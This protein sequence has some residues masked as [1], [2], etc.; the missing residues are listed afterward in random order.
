MRLLCDPLLPFFV[1]ARTPLGDPSA[2][3]WGRTLGE[4]FLF[5][6]INKKM[7]RYE[8]D[9][10]RIVTI[11]AALLLPMMLRAY[12]FSATVASGQT[13]YFNVVA[14]GVQVVYPGTSSQ[15]WVG[16]QVPAGALTIPSTVS[17]NGTVYAIKSVGVKAF[18]TASLTSLTIEEGVE[19]VSINAFG[20]N[21]SLQTVRLPA[22]LNTLASSAFTQCT[23]LQDVYMSSAAPPANTATGA[24]WQVSLE[25]STLHV[26]CG[27]LAAY[28]GAPWDAFG[29]IDAGACSATLTVLSSDLQRGTVS[30]GGTYEAGTLV[31]LNAQ[32]S[33]EFRFVC[34][35]D[36]DTLNPRIVQALHDSLFVAVF[37]RPLR[38]TVRVVE[39]QVDTL[40]I[41]DTLT[42]VQ[43]DTI[44][45]VDTLTIVPTYY[46]LRVASDNEA[47]GLGVGTMTL[48]AGTEAEIG[49]LALE[50]HRF[51][52]W[53]D[54][55]TDNPRR[56]TV[57]G[58]A[59]YTA[60]FETLAANVVEPLAWSLAVNGRE[61]QVYCTVGEAVKVYD[62][63]GR[64]LTEVVAQGPSTTLRM[65]SAG[66]FIVQVGGS[67]GR[68]VT[69]R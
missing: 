6:A 61:V 16:Y 17:N 41:T 54:G 25:N 20:A 53:S 50:G 29:S 48:P 35:N 4:D 59:V 49:A 23:G 68:K 43:N 27:G 12:D 58:D 22:S 60:H 62:L 14:G 63:Q 21:H 38:D 37:Q 2:R 44:E 10:R 1:Y 31:T 33:N 39:V 40:Y 5:Y 26:P 19:E 18:Y 34:W 51:M 45:R 52:R 24:F 47:K 69:L 42:V 28:V 65:A 66:V 3:G 7:V 15:P 64:L 67:G 13:L 36:G 46:S 32:A 8:R 57:T 55:A 11:V 30:G 56:V 9:M